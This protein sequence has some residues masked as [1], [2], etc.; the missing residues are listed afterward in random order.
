MEEL[1]G[2]VKK[3]IFYNEDNH[4]TIA[5][6]K[7]QL[8]RI[9]VKG[10]MTLVEGSEYKFSGRIETDDRYGD[11]FLV[12]SFEELLPSQ[13]DAI[14][15]Y[16]SSSIFRGVGLSSANKIYNALGDECLAILKTNP[17]VLHEIEGLSERVIE[18]IIDKMSVNKLY[19]DLFELLADL[20][21]TEYM[22]NKIYLNVKNKEEPIKYL[23]ENAYRLY[24][25]MDENTIDFKILDSIYLKF[26]TDSESYIR[27][28][29]LIK[30][31]FYDLSF[32]YGDT[33]VNIQTLIDHVIKKR[34]V[35]QNIIEV[36]LEQM[37][38]NGEVTFFDDD[39]QLK[40][41]KIIEQQIARQLKYKD[42]YFKNIMAL[43]IDVDIKKIEHKQDIIFSKAQKQAIKQAINSNISIIT[44]GPGTGKTT[45]LNAIVEILT[46]RVYPDLSKEK[47]AETIALVAPT[48]R[49]SYQMMESSNFSAKTI[50]SLLGIK[51]SGGKPSYNEDNELP[52][53]CFVIDE[54]SMVDTFLFHKL[55]MA[56]KKSAK[57]III[58]DP[59]QL[60]SVGP[61]NLL[62]DFIDSKLFPITNLDVIYRQGKGSS[63][64]KLSEKIIND[65]EI[66]PFKDEEVSIINVT[67]NILGNIKKVV[68]ASL[69]HGFDIFDTQV[70]FTRYK[71][72]VGIDT[73]NEMLH[74]PVNDKKIVY[75]DQEFYQGDKIMVL[76]N[77][78]EHDIYN[79]DIGYVNKIIN[80]NAQGKE[81]AIEIAIRDKKIVLSYKEL[82][83]ITHAYAISV[84]K[85]QG[86]EFPVVI[87]PIVNKSM[88]TKKLIYTA[89]TR[90]KTKLII[91]GNIMALNE[92]LKVNG[93]ERQTN[94]TSYL[95]EG[96]S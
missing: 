94:L 28:S 47:L 4:Y 26:N 82:Y 22:I 63:I 46:K 41:Y 12:S 58:G 8:G 33:L 90:A 84:H 68:N 23:K 93:Y 20:N 9:S 49:A 56:M 48:G 27:V 92:G 61:G 34:N 89:I 2:V 1:R 74:E 30:A 75:R 37:A 13:K 96:E 52:H 67:E 38:S 7:D 11:Y 73:I 83:L 29:N 51:Q 10:N 24:R 54:F 70:L 79:G 42:K 21:L 91:L 69:T 62:R 87:V 19:N 55:L 60:E 40:E 85:S 3:I 80:P 59:N 14:V 32:G 71:G 17:Q 16:L 35:G 31:S 78:Y 53:Q 88:L 77:N 6:V 18:E 25:P 72:E 44:G 45:I 5:Q 36:V 15:T 39:V 64:S 50:H 57:L 43:D 76:R 66:H 95:L 86:S 65:Q 81:E